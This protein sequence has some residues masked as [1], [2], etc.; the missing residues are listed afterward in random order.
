M[1]RF[2]GRTDAALVTEGT[3]RNY[4]AAHRL[5]R[6]FVPFTASGHPLRSRVARN[7]ATIEEI[8]AAYNDANP[9]KEIVVADLPGY[10]AVMEQGIGAFLRPPP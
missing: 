8:I 4:E 1:G 3:D 6:L 2:R 7:M 10:E 9:G 5:G